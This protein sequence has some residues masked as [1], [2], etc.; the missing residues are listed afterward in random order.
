MR[1]WYSE[2]YNR[3]QACA[4]AE[5]RASIRRPTAFG[6]ILFPS[7][8]NFDPLGAEAPSAV[9]SHEGLKVSITVTLPRGAGEDG[10]VMDLG[11]AGEVRLSPQIRARGRGAIPQSGGKGSRPPGNP[12]APGTAPAE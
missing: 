2:S 10:V 9:V 11:G 7:K 3:V 5:Y 4:Q 6:W 8:G 1:G 12:A